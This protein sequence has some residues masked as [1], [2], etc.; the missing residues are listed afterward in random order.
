MTTLTYSAEAVE[1]ALIAASE[2]EPILV[3]AKLLAVAALAELFPSTSMARFAVRLGLNNPSNA[4]KR[5]ARSMAMSWWSDTHVD[6]VVGALV[7][8]QYGDRAL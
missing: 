4:A 8:P 6:H 2:V 7:A 1:A 5:V 3:R